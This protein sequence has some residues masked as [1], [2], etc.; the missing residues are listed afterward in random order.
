MTSTQ[1][2][3][4][5]FVRDKGR[6]N[7]SQVDEDN[8]YTRSM[9]TKFVSFNR[10]GGGWDE[11][12]ALNKVKSTTSLSP[13]GDGGISKVKSSD[14]SDDP[15]QHDV[16]LDGPLFESTS[17][18][19][20]ARTVGNTADPNQPT[21]QPVFK[22]SDAFSDSDTPFS[23][24]SL[25]KTWNVGGIPESLDKQS[26]DCQLVESSVSQA[27]FYRFE[28]SPIES[29]DI[30]A[31]DNDEEPS[32]TLRPSTMSHDSAP[33]PRAL[34]TTPALPSHSHP[35]QLKRRLE[36]LQE[37]LVENPSLDSPVLRYNTQYEYDEERRRESRS[38]TVEDDPP[39]SLVSHQTGSSHAS[40]VLMPG[41]Q[42][43]STTNRRLSPRCSTHSVISDKAASFDFS[44]RL[45]RSSSVLHIPRDKPKMRSQD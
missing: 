26:A 4:S 24:P 36:D 23:R 38:P 5:N 9:M 20:T 8:L 29:E 14:S 2:S 18:N 16:V 22:A 19:S 34:V 25:A 6:L 12:K 21:N 17:L 45:T 7:A 31:N 27:S 11:I 15:W 1:K 41:T 30:V 13:V 33:T 39:A 40:I 32:H 10:S 35:K 43:N 37:Y 42:H 28:D 3:T 44:R